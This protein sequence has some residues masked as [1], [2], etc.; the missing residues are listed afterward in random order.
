MKTNSVVGGK[1]YNQKSVKQAVKAALKQAKKHRKRE[2]AA[3]TERAAK[4]K[5]AAPKPAAKDETSKILGIGQAR[6]CEQLARQWIAAKM[7]G[8]KAFV[9]MLAAQYDRKKRLFGDAAVR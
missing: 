1:C 7:G 9:E 8:A 3:K 6:G 4:T 2:Q 5:P